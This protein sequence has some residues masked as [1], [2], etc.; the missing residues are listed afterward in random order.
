MIDLDDTTGCPRD[1]TCSGCGTSRPLLVTTAETPVGVHCVTVCPSCAQLGLSGTAP[2][3][4]GA[5]RLAL[6]HCAHLGIT[7]DDM[8]EAMTGDSRL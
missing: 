6:D 7:A 2:G 1:D 3:W 5:V 4:A 8:A